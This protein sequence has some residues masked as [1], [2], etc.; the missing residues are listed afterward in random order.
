MNAF[1]RTLFKL[2]AVP[3]GKD[4]AELAGLAGAMTDIA[5]GDAQELSDHSRDIS[6]DIDSGQGLVGGGHQ[7]FCRSHPA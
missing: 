3:G 6:E 4:D 5:T 7:Q 1:L 2:N